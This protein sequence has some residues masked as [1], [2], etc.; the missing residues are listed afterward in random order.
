MDKETH[1]E[2]WTKRK[3]KKNK[4]KRLEASNLLCLPA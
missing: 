2:D 1:G 3:R 4:R